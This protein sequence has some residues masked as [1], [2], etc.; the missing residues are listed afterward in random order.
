MRLHTLR[1]SLGLA[2]SI[3]LSIISTM[4]SAQTVRVGMVLPLSGPQAANG[5]GIDKGAR[6]FEKLH[7]KDLPGL[8]VDIV[9]RD[10]AGSPDNTRRIVQEMIVR[11]KVQ[12]ITGV[13]LSPQGFA[14]A[15]IATEAKIPVVIMNATTASL[16]RASAYFVRVSYTQWHMASSI[17]KWAG[18]NGMK[19]VFSMVADYSAGQ[20]SE[21][22]VK[23]AV[24]RSGGQLVGAIRVPMATTDYLPFM[25]QIKAAKPDALFI[26]INAGRM[27][28]LM[29]AYDEAGLKEAGVKLILPGDNLQDD[30]LLNMPKTIVGATAA[31]VYASSNPAPAN[32]EFVKAWKAEYGENT[33]PNTLAAD[34]WDG[35][36]AIFALIKETKG[37]FDGEKAMSFLSNYK[38]DSSPRGAIAIDPATR[39]IVPTIY[40]TRVEVVN[41]KQTNV[42]QQSIPAVKDPWKDANPQ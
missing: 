15:P 17:G 33:L 20:D 13:A 7:K 4:A 39:D 1:L 38:T 37:K 41:G 18:E 34:G 9:R 27:G 32:V 29:K 16:T 11:D 5:E 25:E 8:Q 31:G 2:C 30:E 35:M 24:E 22:A 23:Q 6:L 40:I 14:I 21:A 12:L 28:S 36:A 3:P 42:I 26:F 10:D 19:K